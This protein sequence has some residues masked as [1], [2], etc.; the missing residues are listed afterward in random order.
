MMTLPKGG[1]PRYAYYQGPQPIGDVFTLR[2]DALTMTCA[3]ATHRLG[4]ELRLTAGRNVVRTHLCKF[5]AEVF[6]VGQAWEDE[7]KRQGW[8]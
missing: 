8:S 7:A 1:L 6:A 3:L 2:R 4:W 5:E